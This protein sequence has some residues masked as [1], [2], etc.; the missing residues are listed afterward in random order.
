MSFKNFLDLRKK[1]DLQ[2]KVV[3]RIILQ[4]R[5]WK[6]DIF[7]ILSVI[8]VASAIIWGIS[9]ADYSPQTDADYTQTT[10]TNTSNS[11]V[12]PAEAGIQSE[13][14]ESAPT[15]SVIPDPIGSPSSSE[16]DSMDQEYFSAEKFP[17]HDSARQPPSLCSETLLSL[18]HIREDDTGSEND[19]V[20]IN[21]ATDTSTTQTQQTFD[22]QNLDGQVATET[23]ATSTPAN[24]D[25]EDL[26]GQT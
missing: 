22:E 14:P 2:I 24:L 25:G 6:S 4:K 16:S 8:F 20:G 15:P 17:D 9:M 5:S 1:T 26:K 12:I 23:P 21:V 13:S 11:A 19:N 7:L 3:E 18:P 10:Q